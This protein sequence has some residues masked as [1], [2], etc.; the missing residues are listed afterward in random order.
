MDR[1]LF[2]CWLRLLAVLDL[3]R[4]RTVRKGSVALCCVS[5]CALCTWQA[6]VWCCIGRRTKHSWSP[7]GV[8]D[9]AFTWPCLVTPGR[10]IAALLAVDICFHTAA[11]CVI[12]R[13]CACC[14]EI[15]MAWFA[16]RPGH[17]RLCCCLTLLQS[18]HLHWRCASGELRIS[19]SSS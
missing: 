5:R 18:I 14:Q 6:D 12:M 15:H 9:H 4:L 13:S 3:G 10:L 17:V 19:R 16:R 2:T 7:C 11:C 8:L 1:C